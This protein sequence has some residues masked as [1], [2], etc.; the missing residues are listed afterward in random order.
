MIISLVKAK[1]KISGM[2]V[3]A[4]SKQSGVSRPSL[5]AFA[6]NT[7]KGVQFETIE[8]LCR[9]FHC[10]ITDVLLYTDTC[11]V[12]IPKIDLFALTPNRTLFDAKIDV[13]TC[14][15]AANL[16]V[17]MTGHEVNAELTPNIAKTNA[18]GK[19]VLENIED[20]AKFKEELE[21]VLADE[22]S[23]AFANVAQ[24][25]HVTVTL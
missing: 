12:V 15:I 18:Y 19:A 10:G 21:K 8:K 2:S 16:A 6:N 22:I 9:F 17:S 20:V 14:K 25:V 24:K 4:L 11:H 23:S 5:I 13:T 1:L 7:A 3:L